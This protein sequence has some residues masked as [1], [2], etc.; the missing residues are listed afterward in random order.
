ML[1]SSASKERPVSF[2][3]V[4][5]IKRMNVQFSHTVEN[6]AATLHRNMT[7]CGPLQI[8]SPA[9]ESSKSFF[10]QWASQCLPEDGKYKSL[11][12]P[13]PPDP[14]RVEV[15]LGQLGPEG[16]LKMRCVYASSELDADKVCCVSGATN[17][18]S[19][20]VQRGVVSRGERTTSAVPSHFFSLTRWHEVC[21]NAPHAI[22]EVL[23]AWE[24]G[25]LTADAVKVSCI[26]LIQIR[27]RLQ[28][29]NFSGSSF[30]VLKLAGGLETA[31]SQI[32]LAKEQIH[33]KPLAPCVRRA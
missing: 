13:A 3:T 26:K 9:Q 8:M 29:G 12:L 27:P 22:L 2:T 33:Q 25:A 6:C 28:D 4:V 7:L 18:E 5:A 16:E 17:V 11:E 21:H 10:A 32:Q 30:C 23:H 19:N 24:A 1:C 31:L 15:L 14:A 20:Y